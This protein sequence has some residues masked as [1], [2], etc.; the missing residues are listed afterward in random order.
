MPDINQRFRKEWNDGFPDIPCWTNPD[1]PKEEWKPIQELYEQTDTNLKLREWIKRK[2]YQNYFVDFILRD[3]KLI[4][5]IDGGHH[6]RPEQVSKDRRK[7]NLLQTLGFVVLRYDAIT[8]IKSV[9]LVYEQIIECLLNN[10][11]VPKEIRKKYEN[12]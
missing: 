1:N 7:S 2:G 12:Y 8:V 10:F 3:Y 5:E 9:D 11:N 4:V 6:S